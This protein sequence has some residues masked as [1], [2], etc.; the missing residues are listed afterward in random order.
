MITLTT[1]SKLT[2]GGE[3]VRVAVHVVGTVP[4]VVIQRGERGPAGPPGASGGTYTHTQ[5]TPSASWLIEHNLGHIPNVAVYIDGKHGLADV[6]VIDNNAVVVTFP[7]ATVGVA[8][9]S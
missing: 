1:R 3:V 2:L 9:L 7:E 4:D 6:E 8:A 5:T